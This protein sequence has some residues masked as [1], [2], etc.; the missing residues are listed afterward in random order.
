MNRPASPG[1]HC[2]IGKY[3][4]EK[5]SRRITSLQGP[6][7]TAFGKKEPNSA[8]FGSIL[9]LSSNPCGCCMSRKERMRSETSS[10]AFTSRAR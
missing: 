5:S 2:K 9:I 4:S 3:W 6:D 1:Q 8:S 7:F 10:I